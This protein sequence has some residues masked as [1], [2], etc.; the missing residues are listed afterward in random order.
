MDCLLIFTN[1]RES[2]TS[3]M[4]HKSDEVNKKNAFVCLKLLVG[5]TY[6]AFLRWCWYRLTA[7]SKYFNE[8]WTFVI[9][10]HLHKSTVC[11]E[12]VRFKI[13][14][15][16]HI[17]VNTLT[18][19]AS[20]VDFSCKLCVIFSFVHLVARSRSLIRFRSHWKVSMNITYGTRYRQSQNACALVC[21]CEKRV[22]PYEKF[23]TT[24]SNRP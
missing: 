11:C 13:I 16:I 19:A 17:H 5:L 22:M 18:E 12:N 8:R 3:F 21:V 14:C 10:W 24:E 23:T 2:S 1:E 15:N 7:V 20:V 9:Q 4:A 6:F